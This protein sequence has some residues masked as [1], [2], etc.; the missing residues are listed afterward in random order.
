MSISL[1]FKATL[2]TTRKIDRRL[3]E[4]DTGMYNDQYWA[5]KVRVD[6]AART[7]KLQAKEDENHDLSEQEYESHRKRPPITWNRFDTPSFGQG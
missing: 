6:W 7:W 1:L 3:K 2:Y 4:E 5:G